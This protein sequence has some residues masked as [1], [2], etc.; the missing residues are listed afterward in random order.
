MKLRLC[1]L[2]LIATG[3]LT[4]L[5]G[6]GGGEIEEAPPVVRPVKTMVL[7]GG[8]EGRRGFPGTVLAGERVVLSFRVG[9]PVIELKVVEGQRVRKGQVLARVDP[10]DYLIALDEAKAAFIKA[11]ADYNRYQR[12]YEQNAVP[13]ADLEF[14]RAQR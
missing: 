4:H 1:T 2:L 14:R 6:C 7:G 5:V 13:L 12:L 11:A 9:G 10:R 8:P 3:S